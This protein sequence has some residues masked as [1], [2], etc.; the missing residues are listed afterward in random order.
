MFDVYKVWWGGLGAPFSAKRVP[1]LTSK[2]GLIMVFSTV[3]ALVLFRILI[4]MSNPDTRF[5][6]G[7]Y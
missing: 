4:W 3:D 5:P 2:G 7:A 6:L 1:L